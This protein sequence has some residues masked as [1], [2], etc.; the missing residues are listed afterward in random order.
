MFKSLRIWAREFRILFLLFVVLPVTLGAAV[1]YRYDPGD[2]SWFYY[3]LTIVA[4]LLLHGG[5]IALNDY[6][7]YKSGN[8][9]ANEDRTKYTGG[10]GLIPDTLSPQTVFIVGLACFILCIALGLFLVFMRSFILLPIGVI[11][12][13][14]GYF[15]SAPPLRLA[16]RFMGEV[17]WFLMMILMPLGAFFVQAPI[18][19][20]SELSAALDALGILVVSS[21]PLA[22]MGT[23]GIY[24]LEFPDY[25][26]DRI[27][28][29]WNLSTLF[30]RKNG[31]YIFIALSALSYL[32]LIAGIFLDLIPPVAIFAIVT[33]PL[34]VFA[35][36]GLRRYYGGAKNIVQFIEM[37]I[38]T[39]VLMG[40]IL[41][42][43]FLL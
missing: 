8:D 22:F 13:G 34:V 41:I 29:K 15:Y 23:V 28:E 35:A 1:A 27:A 33:L 12:V 2:F 17:S 11:G 9:P 43:S 42:A 24:I 30:G 19:S 37:V 3:A 26:A 16:Y 4:I 18:N 20:F 25:H 14:V 21:L 7:D 31:L 10:T 6:F 38:V 5:T 40:V 39:N 36:L 32:S